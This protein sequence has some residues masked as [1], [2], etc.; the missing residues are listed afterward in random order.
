MSK[1]YIANY[2]NAIKDYMILRVYRI[3]TNFL[4]FTFKATF[5]G[6]VYTKLSN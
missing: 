6:I 3:N 4:I 5:K 1:A 2:C